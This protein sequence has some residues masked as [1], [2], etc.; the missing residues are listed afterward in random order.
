MEI[1]DGLY[2]KEVYMP[3]YRLPDKDIKVKYSEHA[4]QQAYYERYDIIDLKDSYNF[5]KAEIIE[6]EVKHGQ[7]VKMVAR[8]DYNN[9]YDLI[10]VIIPQTK[11]IKTVWLNKKN[12]KHTTLNRD[13]YNK[14]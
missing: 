10:I 11:V 13:R 5:S 9:K 1:K 12:D 2:H 7:A 6:L 3:A 14:G 8:F 4:L